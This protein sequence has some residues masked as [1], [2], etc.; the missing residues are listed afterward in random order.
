MHTP[1]TIVSHNMRYRSFELH[2]V[3]GVPES[4]G[5][6]AEGVQIYFWSNCQLCICA[7]LHIVVLM[8]TVTELIH[9]VV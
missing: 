7:E 4:N 6:S 1:N 9:A 3:Q 8:N 2:P 5:E